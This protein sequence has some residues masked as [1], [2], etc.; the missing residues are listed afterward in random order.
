MFRQNIFL[1]N[2]GGWVGCY[3]Q[4]LKENIKE[5]VFFD[6]ILKNVFLEF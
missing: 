2:L 3:F 4:F 6:E 1:E 5:T